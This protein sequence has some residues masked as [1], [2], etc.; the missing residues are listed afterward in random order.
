MSPEWVIASCARLL[1]EREEKSTKHDSCEPLE[2]GILRLRPL[3]EDSGVREK[4]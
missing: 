3:K 1:A 4:F 2:G